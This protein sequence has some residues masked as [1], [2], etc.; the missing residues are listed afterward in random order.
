[1]TKEEA[2]KKITFW[3]LSLDM[4][5]IITLAWTFFALNLMGLI[6]YWID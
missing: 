1:M 6:L 2:R 3:D 4:Q 5:I